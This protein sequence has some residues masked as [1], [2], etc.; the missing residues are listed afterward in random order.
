MFY[1]FLFMVSYCH[2][3]DVCYQVINIQNKS[4]GFSRALIGEDGGRKLSGTISTRTHSS[5]GVTSN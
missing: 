2:V 3:I 1:D 4:S 5:G